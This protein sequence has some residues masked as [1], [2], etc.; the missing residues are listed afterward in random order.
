[1]KLGEFLRTK[2]NAMELC[3]ITNGGWVVATVW[4]DHEDI[5]IGLIPT[6]LASKPVKRDYW[7]YLTIVNENNTSIKVPCHFIDV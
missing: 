1:M 4:I 2:T 6:T 7:D 3:A 5:F